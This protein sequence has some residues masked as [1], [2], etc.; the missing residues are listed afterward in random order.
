[1]TGLNALFIVLIRLF[2]DAPVVWAAG[3]CMA[4]KILTLPSGA[5]TA[6]VRSFKAGKRRAERRPEQGSQN[7]CFYA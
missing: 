7:A 6:P 3:V 4:K 5:R 2:R 1:M